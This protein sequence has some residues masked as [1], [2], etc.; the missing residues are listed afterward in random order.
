MVVHGAIKWQGEKI[1]AERSSRLAAVDVFWAQS[2]TFRGPLRPFSFGSLFDLSVLDA[3]VMLLPLR[4]VGRC[5]YC[6]KQSMLP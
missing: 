2:L 6:C 1:V 4:W 5:F 3:Y